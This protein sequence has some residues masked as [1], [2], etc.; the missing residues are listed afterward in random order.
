[1][2]SATVVPSKI[3]VSYNSVTNSS[4]KLYCCELVNLG[5]VLLALQISDKAQAVHKNP[6]PIQKHMCSPLPFQTYELFNI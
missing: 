3:P 5:N 1:M 2:D 6:F 4:L